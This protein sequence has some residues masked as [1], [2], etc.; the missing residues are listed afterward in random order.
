MPVPL[1]EFLIVL[2]GSASVI[3]AIY[4]GMTLILGQSWVDTHASLVFL[5]GVYGLLIPPLVW[6]VR[7]RPNGQTGFQSPKVKVILDD[8]LIIAEPC[9][10]MGH[11][12]AVSVFKLQ[13]DV[14]L[15]V[16]SAY[17]VNIQSNKLVQLRP[18]LL[19][20]AAYDVANLNEIKEKLLI[21]PGHL[22]EQ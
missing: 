17:V 16:F 13:D 21:K 15:F 22:H 8:G 5:N 10:W 14:E 9:E 2:A 3:G 18:I 12:T 20:A 4:I 1:K 6:M 11:R 19:E 7:Y